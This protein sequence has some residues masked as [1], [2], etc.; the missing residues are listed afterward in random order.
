LGCLAALLHPRYDRAE[1]PNE[2]ADAVHAAPARLV[3]LSIALVCLAAIPGLLTGCGSEEPHLP[4]VT[5][6]V[7][8]GPRPGEAT[9]TVKSSGSGTGVAAVVL[10]YPDGHRRQVGQ[11]VLE[12]VTDL[13]YGLTDLPP[14]QYT[15]TIYAVATPSVP[16]APTLPAGAR[17]DKNI[18]A[19]GTFVLD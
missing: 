11:G 12:G 10:T 2:G 4:D 8:V 17:V 9:V 15:Y 7:T 1:Y 6:G 3:C 19:S 18:I 14:G 5:A 16:A 13:G